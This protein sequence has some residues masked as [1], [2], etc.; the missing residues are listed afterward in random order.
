MSQLIKKQ[1]KSNFLR[2]TKDEYSYKNVFIESFKEKLPLFISLFFM[3]IVLFVLS[4]GTDCIVWLL[5]VPYW[6][7]LLARIPVIIY[8]FLSLQVWKNKGGLILETFFLVC[9]VFVPI[10]SAF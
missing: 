1:L 9:S 2:F 4:A 7:S 8:A 6:Y 5:N 10:W 3:N